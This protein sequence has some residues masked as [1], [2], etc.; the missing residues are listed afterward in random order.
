MNIS[1]EYAY[2]NAGLTLFFL[3][4]LFLP[5]IIYVPEFDENQHE[6]YKIHLPTCE[7]LKRTGHVCPGCGLTRSIVT[8]YQGN[9]ELSLRYHK[10]GILV[11]MFLI[12]Q[13]CL[14]LLPILSKVSWIPWFDI[15]QITLSGALIALSFYL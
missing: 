4:I 6:S 2:V 1:K 15:F 7:V 11:I 13:T 3:I 12:L 10:S 14:R 5:F 8:L 9:L